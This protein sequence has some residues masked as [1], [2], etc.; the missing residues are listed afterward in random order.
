MLQFNSRLTKHKRDILILK[1]LFGQNVVQIK[2]A[3][4]EIAI[5]FWM[6]MDPQNS[7]GA[8][9]SEKLHKFNQNYMR[10]HERQN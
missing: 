1:V 2:A 4:K 6:E 7:P 8:V 10:K 3:P 9:A 5:V